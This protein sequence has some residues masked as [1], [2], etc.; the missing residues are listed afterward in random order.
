MTK[1]KKLIRKVL[2]EQKEFF[3]TI[4]LQ[5]EL[6]AVQPVK[7]MS[8]THLKTLQRKSNPTGIWN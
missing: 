6:I 3:N 2:R 8:M 1:F 7:K 5:P 4:Q